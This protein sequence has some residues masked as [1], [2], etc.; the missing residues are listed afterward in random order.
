MDIQSMIDKY[1]PEIT[2]TLKIASTQLYDKVLWY[3]RID[4]W[5]QLMTYALVAISYIVG[6]IIGI[7][8][9]KK[10]WKWFEDGYSTPNPLIIFPALGF[11]LFYMLFPLFVSDVVSNIS[12]I[13]APE[14]WII[15]QIINK[16]K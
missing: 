16:A 10:N 2:K 8:L 12:K 9:I 6:T 13:V 4:G 1:G 5:V 7:K 14:Y 3:T 11:V 15:N